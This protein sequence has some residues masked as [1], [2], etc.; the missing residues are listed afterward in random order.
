MHALCSGSPTVRHHM[1]ACAPA[2][3]AGQPFFLFSFIILIVSLLFL[4]V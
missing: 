1:L 4:H 2:L 3:P